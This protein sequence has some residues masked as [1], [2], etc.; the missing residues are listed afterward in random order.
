METGQTH[1]DM[2]I[3]V[4]NAAFTCIVHL[5]QYI[6]TFNARND[7]IAECAASRHHDA[8]GGGVDAAVD[9]VTVKYVPSVQLEMDE[10]NE[11]AQLVDDKTMR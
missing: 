10:L 11:A 8:D 4:A 7:G 3:I 1:G 5:F 2:N 9:R 6:T